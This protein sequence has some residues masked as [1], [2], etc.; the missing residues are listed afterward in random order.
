MRLFDTSHSSKNALAIFPDF[1]VIA[2][3][4]DNFAT[5][6]LV[7][8][9]CVL[10]GKP[11]V[12]ASVFRFEGQAAVFAAENGPCYRCLYPVPPPPAWFHRAQKAE[13]LAFYP[14]FSG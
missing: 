4:T 10:S 5:R 7:N 14:G 8:D 6:Y 11:Y 2:D 13:Y 9:A 3:G 1:D 12:Y